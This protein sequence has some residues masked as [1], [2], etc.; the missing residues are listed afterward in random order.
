MRAVLRAIHS[1]DVL[2]LK[3]W[4]P[5][6]GPFGVFIQLFVGNTE[7]PRQDAFGLTVC[8]PEWIADLASR[9]NAVDLRHHVLMDHWDYPKL[10]SY[11]GHRVRITE[12]DTW[13]QIGEK[14]GRLGLW[15]YEDYSAP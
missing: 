10:E 14:L 7:G 2:D 9:Y 5:P 3:S 15:D 11:L 12:G 1:P 8:N 6:P 4:T 13:D